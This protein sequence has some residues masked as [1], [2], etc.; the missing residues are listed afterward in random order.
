MPLVKDELAAVGIEVNIDQMP[1]QTYF[2]KNGPLVQGAFELG[3]YADVG[4]QD[5]GVDVVTKFG[6]KFIP[7]NANN[8]AGQNFA[9]WNNSTGDQL[10]TAESTT[11]VP[12][13]RSA[14]MN[15]LQLV[16]ADDLPLLPLF[17]RPNVTAAS[18]RLANYKP[19][20]ANNGN[21]WNVWEWDLR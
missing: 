4:T 7:T 8:F 17:F 9:R 12:G 1:A 14:A 11:L 6:S 18:N 10:I 20:Y 19:E 21:N 5:S 13:A 3:E 15:A 16:L 2:G